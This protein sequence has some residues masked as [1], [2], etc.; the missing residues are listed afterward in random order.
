MLYFS[1]VSLRPLPL[2]LLLARK[3]Y[4]YKTDCPSAN[5]SN[6]TPAVTTLVREREA[7]KSPLNRAQVIDMGRGVGFNYIKRLFNMF[8]ACF[9]VFFYIVCFCL[10]LI[11][12]NQTML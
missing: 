10:L 2:C 6:M 1:G 8:I 12:L 3:V 7:K 9:V 5:W 11:K 4:Y